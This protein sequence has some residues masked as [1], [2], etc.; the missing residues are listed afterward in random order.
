MASDA[1]GQGGLPDERP[2]LLVI[3]VRR[4]LEERV[5]DW[6]LA[7]DDVGTFSSV[8]VDVHGVDPKALLGAERVGGRQ[9][10]TELRVRI[11]ASH[12][13]ELA[14]AMTSE[15]R[16][17]ELEWFVVAIEAEGRHWVG[18]ATSG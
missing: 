1:G 7:R 8:P 6:L 17:A 18:S 15:F 12:L 4:A 14:D 2:F 13:A 10:R 11:P 5:I 16:G 3:S 9:R